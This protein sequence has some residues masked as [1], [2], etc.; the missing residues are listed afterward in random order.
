MCVHVCVRVR[1]PGSSGKAS[2]QKPSPASGFLVPG[3]DFIN[4]WEVAWG[5]GG[6][7]AGGRLDNFWAHTAHKF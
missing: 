2:C 7:A 5:G 4:I 1:L 6:G 3:E